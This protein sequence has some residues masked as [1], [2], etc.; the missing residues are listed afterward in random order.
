MTP[1]TDLSIWQDLAAHWREIE[2]LQMRDLFAQDPDRF[3]R[4]S[5]EACGI[6]L[7]YSKN[8]ISRQTLDLLLE[9]AEVA[10]VRGWTGRMFAGERIN[11]S[12]HRSV[13]HVA[14]RNRT[15]PSIRVDGV[16]I[17]PEV[18]AV[19]ERMRVFSERVRS[20][21]W[22]GY[23]GE[24]ITDVVNIGIGGSNL[25]PLMV[26]EAL[27]P[28]QSPRLRVHF[29]SNVDPSHLRETLKALDPPRTLFVVASKTFTTLETLTNARAARRW[30]VDA[31]GS[32]DAV[33]RHFVAVSSAAER[34]RAFGIDTDHMFGFW[35]W[36]G[37]R[38]SLW[39]AIGLPIALAVGMEAFEK[40]LAGAHAMDEH[41]RSA[42]PP[43]SMPLI[44]ALLGI[45][46]RD[47]AGAA[48]HAVLP[49]DQYLRYLPA[50]L[51]QADMESNGK[52]VTRDGHVVDYQTG[53]VVWGAAGTDG[54]H[55]F[56]Q[57]I[58]QG[59]QL[60]PADFVASA[61]SHNELDD[62]HL[63]L[64]ANFLAQPEALM[65]GK[66]VDE[67]RGEMEQTRLD[68]EEMAAL[69]PHK[70]FPGNRPTNSLLMERLTPD[71][72]G[73]LIA[74][75]EHKIFVQG[76]IWQVNSFDQWG[77]ELGKELAAAILP[78]LKGEL[79]GVH[80]AST[81]GLIRRCRSLRRNAG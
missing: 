75:Y 78:E 11:S 61:R 49:Y 43:D 33:E 58:H 74:L 20:G 23:T 6:L 25:G 77:V 29:V 10:D 81:A 5:L 67:A 53:P 19:L 48:T 63:K 27:L 76:V 60:V 52:R 26:C 65:R 18:R 28:Y 14:L 50:Y 45:W 38:Y 31:L 54:Q 44:L 55:A 17:M 71:S 32:E 72:L 8:R 46:Y 39:S 41:F 3:E 22:R 70:V 24:P 36:V 4:F 7:D 57:L 2:P 51:Q 47:F 35:D 15:H 21:E 64:L 30:V 37:G 73:A 34:V 16:D 62:Q 1:L 40:L 12:E 9:L 79:E 69:V 68:A 56:Y 13:L 42:E 80:D 59:T 66:T